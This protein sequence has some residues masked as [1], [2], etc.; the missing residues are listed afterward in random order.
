MRFDPRFLEQHAK[1]LISDPEVAFVELIS[2]CSDA[3]ADLVEISWPRGQGEEFLIRDNGTG[4]THDEFITIWETLA[5]NRRSAGKEILFPPGNAENKNRKLYGKN[6]K[7]RFS[8]FCFDDQY[9]VETVK[10]GQVSAF[11]VRRNSSGTNSPFTVDRIH[12]QRLEDTSTPG[13]LIAANVFY[14]H[15][16]YDRLVELIG[17][18][19]LA[20]PSLQIQVNGRAI[21][22]TDV[23]EADCHEVDTPHGKIYIYVLDRSKT[24]RTGQ[25][26]GV[27]WHVNGKAVGRI[28]W[29]DPNRVV[30]IDVDGRTAEAK[31]HSFIVVADILEDFVSDDWTRFEITDE[32]NT[33]LQIGGEFIQKL[34]SDLF[35]ERHRTQKRLAMD[36]SR[37][38]LK[39]LPQSSKERV[40]GLVD[41]LQVA[42]PTVKQD[43]L[44]ATVRVYANMEDARTG[45]GL[46]HKL[47]A[48]SPD[49]I[50]TW[51]LILSR[52]SATD[53]K[54]VLEELGTR[55]FL[56][57]QIEKIINANADELHE[58]HPLFDRGLW[59]F[60]PEFESPHFRS[61]KWLS[62]VVREL[63]GDNE[64]QVER[65]QR[66]PD[67]VALPDRR[68]RVF[69]RDSFD[70][71]GEVDGV[72]KVLIIELKSSKVTLDDMRQ[73]E[74]YARAIAASGQVADS[75]KI[76]CYA[77]GS[78]IA[79]GVG[80][81]EAN[82]QIIV[83]SRDYQT[84]IRQAQARTFFLMQTIAEAT[85]VQSAALM[86]QED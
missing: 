53:A 68:L 61:N 17:T 14:N 71:D 38:R 1:R 60:G 27:A 81:N 30:S 43:V 36:Y 11:S 4:M 59:I 44:N 28:A 77:L 54:I 85:G 82:S 79:A 39:I 6:G 45:Y 16:S 49:D 20:D 56:I 75:T 10:D 84:V 57:R 25:Q 52:W 12:P 13:T 83:Q 32:T 7:G 8:L 2:N 24:G 86:E 33:V 31:R 5:Y 78:E 26:H 76:L 70:D 73:V 66:R 46:L 58:I 29:R 41:G 55:L 34:V 42:L 23:V 21:E 40:E 67:L 47:A 15:I 35:T 65:P 50:D 72:D 48:A 63:I 69:S 18:T 51:F 74:D 37:E 80:K 19:F 22:L 64:I 3:G 62:T 9:E